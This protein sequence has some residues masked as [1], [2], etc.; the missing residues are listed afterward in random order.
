MKEIKI[1]HIGEDYAVVEIKGKPFEVSI[2]FAE[3]LD[4]VL[5]KYENASF[6]IRK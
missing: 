5:K 1:T 6:Y 4:K 3:A 2:Y